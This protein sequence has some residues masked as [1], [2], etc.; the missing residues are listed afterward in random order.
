MKPDEL[1][2]KAMGHAKDQ[3]QAKLRNLQTQILCCGTILSLLELSDSEAERVTKSQKTMLAQYDTAYNEYCAVL[4]EQREEIEKLLNSAP[5]VLMAAAKEARTMHA[6]AVVEK[7]A[8]QAD[9][10]RMVPRKDDRVVV[11]REGF[12][13]NGKADTA[14]FPKAVARKTSW[15]GK[16]VF[17]NAL[18][19]VERHASTK[20]FKGWSD[21]RCCGKKNGSAEHKRTKFG[22]TF[23]WPSGFSHYIEEHNIRP[24][25]AFQDWVMAQSSKAKT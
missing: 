17:L 4:G 14:N 18:A 23:V 8:K 2:V 16:E 10:I 6:N 3:A 21:C 19:Y 15:P 22:V 25:L 12:W 1:K 24:S 9:K 13:T 11:M 20:S 5:E 7:T